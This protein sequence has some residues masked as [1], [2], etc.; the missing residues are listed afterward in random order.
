MPSQF[1]GLN[2]AYTG[3]L[4]SNAGLNTTA[5]NIS[6][7][8][9]QGY[10]RQTVSQA[11]TTALRTFQ[12]YGCAGAGVDVLAIER[13]RDEFYDVKY[14]NNNSNY[15][16]YDV[17]AY[18]MSQFERYFADNDDIEGFNTIFNKMYDAMAE[19]KKQSGDLSSKTQFVGFAQSLTE[20][21]NDLAGNLEKMQKDMND[22]IKNKVDNINSLATE[23][24]SL[25]QQINVIEM[26]GSAANELRDQRTVLID[27][28]S[29]VVDVEVKET[30]IYDPHY[31][32]RFTG[33][34]NFTVKICGGQ[35]LVD[36]GEY[37][38]LECV[39]RQKGNKANQS[40]IDGLYDIR[41]SNGLEVNLHGKNLGGELKALVEMRDG[42]NG[43]NFRGTVSQVTQGT[44]GAKD[45]VTIDVTEDYLE[46]LNKCILSDT[47]GEISLGN[48]MFN[49][50][51]WSV[52]K[53]KDG[54]YSYTFT[55]SSD[56][57]NKVNGSRI[58]KEAEVGTAVNYQGVPYYQEQMNE[59]VRIFA[60]KFNEILTQPNAVDSYGNDAVKL[61]VADDSMSSSQLFFN[62]EKTGNGPWS[63]DSSDDTYYK[64]T[65]KNFAVNNDVISDPG[66]FATYTKNGA[67]GDTETVDKYNILEELINMKSDTK[68][69]KF[70]NSSASEFLQCITSD[71][72]LNANRANTFC[73]N[74]QNLEQ[75]IDIMRTSI[76]GV[77]EDE[78]AVNLTK[79]QNAFSL[80]SRMIQ[81]FTEIYDRLILS[82]GV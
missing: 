49:Y 37:N 38:T 42:N 6:N 78:E 8:Q 21:F 35:T 75:S 53:K 17:K 71:V 43:E 46:D 15:G 4:A 40:D 51:S 24:S 26:S 28:L 13:V 60:A 54:S 81:T 41:W 45:T 50:D 18:Y 70:R 30:P 20:Y 9:T 5:N 55:L 44:G 11:A 32:D 58:G 10:S 14:W 22:E 57:E 2:I 56:N 64:L 74:F 36:S 65:A 68:V 62:Q 52:T 39:A 77:D 1:F 19:V 34:Y 76:S 48:Q 23:I 27:K 80:A 73:E 47:G 59:F 66:K 16:Q 82:T 3:L 29:K 31:P 79:Y 63:V 67:A 61:F 69:L 25:N 12:T 72:T 33:A 7:V